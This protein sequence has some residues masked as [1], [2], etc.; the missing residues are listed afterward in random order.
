SGGNRLDAAAE[1]VMQVEAALEPATDR[2]G[3]VEEAEGRDDADP[4]ESAGNDVVG[5]KRALA[6]DE[7]LVGEHR[8]QRLQ[9]G[10]EGAEAFLA[11]F[12][13]VFDPL[14]ETRLAGAPEML[15]V[16]RRQAIVHIHQHGGTE[17]A[18]HHG[19][20]PALDETRGGLAALA[21]EE[22]RLAGIGL[23]QIE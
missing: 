16:G 23:L 22:R 3:L 10:A 1:A 14:A 17:I 20:R 9:R 6:A 13:H 5:K 11:A 2:I 4:L 12:G 19:L 15:L 21:A 8:A 18:M 7:G